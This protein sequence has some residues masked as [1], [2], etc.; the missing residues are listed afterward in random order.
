MGKKFRAVVYGKKGFWKFSRLYENSVQAW[1]A[2]QRIARDNKL[3]NAEIIITETN[4]P[5][6]NK[7]N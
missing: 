1:R 2:G 4:E 7:E 5:H 6:Y 3:D